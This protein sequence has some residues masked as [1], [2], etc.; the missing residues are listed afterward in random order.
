MIRNFLLFGLLSVALWADLPP[1][2]LNKIDPIGFPKESLSIYIRD[3]SSYEP[4]ATL[5]ELTSRT[6]ASVEKLL[7]TYT[8]LLELG[9]GYRWETKI[10]HDG[11]IENGL[12]N[13]NLIIRASGDPT[14]SAADVARIVEQIKAFGIYKISGNVIVDRTFFDVPTDNSSN[15]DENPYDPYNA[16][17]DAMMFN[18]RVVKLR[19]VPKDGGGADILQDFADRSFGIQNH[20][21]STN[22]P[23]EAKNSMPNVNINNLGEYSSI[24]LGGYLSVNCGTKTVSKVLSQ[25]YKSF[26]HALEDGFVKNGVEFKGLLEIKVP[27]SAKYLFSHYSKPLIEI[28]AQT[29]KPSNNLLARQIFLTLGTNKFRQVSNIERSRQ[30]LQ[31]TLIGRGLVEGELFVN[32]GSG[33]SR[34]SI[35]SAKTL[36]NVLHDGASNRGWRETLSV[37][38]VDGTLKSRF[39]SSIA[40][41]K[42]WM[43]SGTIK[44]VTNLA[45]YVE[46]KSGK[47]YEVVILCNNPQTSN[48]KMVANSVVEWVAGEL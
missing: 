7:T 43:K 1:S 20:I 14:L 41:S 42:A 45:G 36:A 6:P 22:E 4:L 47:L 5:N 25:P 28:L 12:L 35:L 32:N 19:V 29:N 9:E 46:G 21:I 8:A 17:P 30:A 34:D 33:L 44:N 18:E 15:F 24:D 2:L 10:Y 26:F 27:Q 37:A 40:Q 48:G 23:C 39:S 11:V 3:V 31:T 16:M 13:G 38:G